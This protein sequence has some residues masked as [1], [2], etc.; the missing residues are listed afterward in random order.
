MGARVRSRPKQ[1]MKKKYGWLMVSVVVLLLM[2]ACGPQMATPTTSVKSGDT[3]STPTQ[4]AR[5]TEVVSTAPAAETA[6]VQPPDYS[7]LP[8]DAND[9][10]T[11][12][13][14]DAPVT[15]VEYSDFQ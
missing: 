10:R 13:S 11:L 8:V 12:G 15:I 9:W 5:Q 14:P 6:E 2:A 4:V 3:E 1:G 7:E